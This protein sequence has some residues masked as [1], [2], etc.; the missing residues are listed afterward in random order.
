M[1]VQVSNTKEEPKKSPKEELMALVKKMVESTY[2]AQP[3]D[4]PLYFLNW[5]KKEKG[6]KTL[7]LSLYQDHELSK[8]RLQMVRYKALDE[9][10][11]A[12]QPKEEDYLSDED[13]DDID[14]E[15]DKEEV[16]KKRMAT[17][18]RKEISTE[19]YTE[20]DKPE[21]YTPKIV[22]KPPEL[23]EA[24]RNRLIRLFHF[25]AFD[26]DYVLKVIDLMY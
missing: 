25:D 16:I 7:G 18:P 9:S 6:F 15:L 10:N 24:I 17:K 8:L 3:E 23:I 1:K 19:V 20:E 13:P 2:I 12:N 21:E 22:E 4:V 11:K 5:L 26:Y 14:E